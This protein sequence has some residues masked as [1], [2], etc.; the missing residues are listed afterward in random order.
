MSM[1]FILVKIKFDMNINNNEPLKTIWKHKKKKKKLMVTNNVQQCKAQVFIDIQTKLE[2]FYW[3]IW[4]T[5]KSL[6]ME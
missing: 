6:K 5:K 1:I 3:C 4:C 2:P